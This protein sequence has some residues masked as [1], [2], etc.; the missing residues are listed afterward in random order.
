M[1]YNLS[2]KRAALEIYRKKMCTERDKN[3]PDKN[4]AKKVICDIHYYSTVCGWYIRL[5]NSVSFK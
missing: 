5:N 3:A 1:D 2:S 4:E